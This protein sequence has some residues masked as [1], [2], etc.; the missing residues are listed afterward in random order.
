LQDVPKLGCL[1]LVLGNQSKN[2]SQSRGTQTT[3]K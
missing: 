2:V 1:L 3:V